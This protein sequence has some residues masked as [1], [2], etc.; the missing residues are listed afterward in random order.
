[1]FPVAAQGARESLAPVR[2]R[3]C[4]PDIHAYPASPGAARLHPGYRGFLVIPNLRYDDYIAALQDDVLLQ[5][6]TFL[7]PRIFKKKYFLLTINPA[8]NLYFID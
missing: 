4:P 7:H 8:N 5:I 1:M 6:F 2:R 3:E